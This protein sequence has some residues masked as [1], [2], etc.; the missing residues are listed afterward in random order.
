MFKEKY[1]TPGDLAPI[2]NEQS[3]LIDFLVLQASAKAIGIGVSTFSFY[4]QESRLMLGGDP[5]NTALLMLPFIGTDELFYMSA[6]T[7]IRTRKRLGEQH[8]LTDVCLRRD[9]L[10]CF[11]NLPLASPA[12]V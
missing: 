2:A 1:L 7:A 10:P 5:L 4:L 6:V 3:G 11:S 8:R 12:F 9:R